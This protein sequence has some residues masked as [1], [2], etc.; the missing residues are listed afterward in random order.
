MLYKNI[1]RIIG[2]LLNVAEYRLKNDYFKH[3][4]KKYYQNIAG[5]LQKCYL[6]CALLLYY[7]LEFSW[8]R[9]ILFVQIVAYGLS[10]LTVSL[11]LPTGSRA[12][13]NKQQG[14]LAGEKDKKPVQSVENRE[15]RP[16]NGSNS[17]RSLRGRVSFWTSDEALEPENERIRVRCA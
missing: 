16:E 3:F 14:W 1:L 6:Y 15:R 9:C 4:L 13:M 8:K 7:R 12:Q 11:H 10:G 5:I 2:F 17:T